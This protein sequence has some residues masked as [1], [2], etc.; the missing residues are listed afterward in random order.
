M[1]RKSILL[2]AIIAV[3]SI[4]VLAGRQVSY[5][6]ASAEMVTRAEYSAQMWLRVLL[7]E[8]DKLH[9]W[10][11]GEQI[12]ERDR[13]Q[14][15][16]YH[17][18]SEIYHFKL[19]DAQGQLR[20]ES[21]QKRA[22]ATPG[23][24]VQNRDALLSQ[25]QTTA[26]PVTQMCAK[27]RYAY[28]PS[29]CAQSF[30]PVVS[31]GQ[32]L[33]VFEASLDMSAAAADVRD[34]YYLLILAIGSLVVIAMLVPLGIVLAQS[35]RLRR[36]VA[37]VNQARRRAE[38]AE[39]AKSD[40]LAQMSHEIRTPLNG[41]VGMFDLLKQSQLDEEQTAL[42]ETITHS[43]RGLVRI[44]NDI[45]D[46]SKIEAGQMTLVSESFNLLKLTEDVV[47]LF[48]HA[49][50]AKPV[51]ITIESDLPDKLEFIGDPLR[52]RQCLVNL[53]GNAVKFT[54]EGHIRV[55]VTTDPD[56][57][58]SIKV[59]DT[60]PG[61]A[62]AELGHIFDAFAQI[63][64]G[65]TRQ[66]DGAGLGLTITAELA[67]LMGGTLTAAS[68]LGQGAQFELRLPLTP[69]PCSESYANLWK[70]ARKTL[71]GKRVL[72]AQS[73][74][75]F[76][77]SL[78]NSLHELGAI[79]ICCSSGAEALEALK[80]RQDQHAALDLCLVDQ[81]LDDMPGEALIETLRKRTTGTD[82][83][84]IL[85]V[86]ALPDANTQAPHSAA[87]VRLLRKPAKLRELI[88]TMCEVLGTP[89]EERKS[90]VSTPK[91]DNPDLSR[92]RIMLV[93]DNRTNQLVVQKLLR[94]TGAEIEIANNGIEAV[95]KFKSFQPDLVLMDIAMPKMNGHEATRLIRTIE[96]KNSEH[97]STPILAL[98][99]YTMPEDRQ[100]C[101][102][103]GMNGFL[104]K[105][106]KR[107]NLIDSIVSHLEPDEAGQTPAYPI[108]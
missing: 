79:P 13:A 105:P 94:K 7:A 69:S 77:R 10:I 35:V 54:S 93:E 95:E 87:G 17:Q 40:F 102:A 91:S 74:V 86:D 20:L 84:C 6:I 18:A 55:R 24:I 11:A 45:L 59:S 27:Q 65:A 106:V 56:G 108:H 81:N 26:L 32:T 90:V 67:K 50:T 99:A 47:S 33:G 70:T 80:T 9:S 71:R 3:L 64:T 2:L 88:A 34:A 68:T 98:T 92:I 78:C 63:D 52:L 5:G 43:S 46:F 62:E 16:S 8:E 22:A 42:A 101:Q 76:M 28:A 75:L 96:E 39:R 104:S 51:Q 73:N 30:V 14:L 41:V 103:S 66:F 72:I 61:I 37:K 58:V 85:L 19:Y 1:R 36:L 82:M 83:N 49:L 44:I 48:A 57:L 12:G 23:Q 31:N 21:G 29:Y 25:A 107:T 4:C 89:L 53:I 60:G 15:D 100:A 97:P 38:T